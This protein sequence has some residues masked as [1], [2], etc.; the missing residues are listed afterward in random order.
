VIIISGVKGNPRYRQLAGQW[1]ED[2][3]AGAGGSDA[4]G[5]GAGAATAGSAAP[6][7][8]PGSTGGIEDGAFVIELQMQAAGG[9]PLAHERVRIHDPD[10]GQQI[11]SAAVTDENGVLRARVPAEKEYH[12]HLD[13]DAAEE[14]ADAFDDHDHPLAARLPHPDEHAVLHVAFSDAKGAPRK[15]ET[16]KI[17]DEHGQSRELQTDEG[18]RFELVVDHGPFTLEVRGARFQAHSVMSGDLAGEAAPYHFVV[19]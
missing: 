14:H 4:G 19:P 10:T 15:G 16:V 9:T 18:G 3:S 5:S 1:E 8:E 12:L 7:L 17:A 11:G 13:A 2:G 6:A